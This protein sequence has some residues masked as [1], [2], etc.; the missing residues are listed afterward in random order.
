MATL[1]DR[2]FG[3]NP[4]A[5]KEK[6]MNFLDHL[7]ELRWH[8]I[9]SVIAL[10]VFFI[11]TFSFP[12][13]FF[14][15]VIMGPSKIEFVTY[16][17]FCNLSSAIGIPDLCIDQL[18]FAVQNRKMHGQFTMHI[19]YSFVLALVFA[20]PYLFWEIWR[21]I[22][23]GLYDNEIKATNGATI[24]VSLLFLVGV[25]FGYFI[26]SPV[27]INFLG[28]YQIVETSNIL[29]E[30]DL[31]SYVE[32]VAMLVLSCGIAF[33]LPIVIL[34]LSQIGVVNPKMLRS[35]RK[36]AVVTI[37]V[38]SAIITPPEPTSQLFLALP[39]YLL[40]EFS[41]WISAWIVDKEATKDEINTRLS[42]GI[43]W[44][45]ALI[46]ILGKLQQQRKAQ[47]Y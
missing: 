43:I 10:V 16:T 45:T 30:I 22:K 7:E 21:F 2:Q 11:I 13:F 17:T 47:A 29:N 20:F 26:V 40:Y 6:E 4:Q 44:I 9:R 35:F 19:F 36:H 39:L 18:N 31:T 24:F 42:M 15:T 33:Q 1:P 38:I 34:F 8:L 46:G 41:I 23:P 37:L 27:A 14:E 12:N 28:N 3:E 5:P 25:S 32:T